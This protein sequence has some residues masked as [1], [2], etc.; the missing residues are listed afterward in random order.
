MTFVER[1][2]S[3]S[4]TVPELHMHPCCSI[5]ESGSSFCWKQVMEGGEPAPV[6]EGPG[7][8]I[9]VGAAFVNFG[10]STLEVIVPGAAVFV[11]GGMS[12]SIGGRVR[13]TSTTDA[14][15]GMKEPVSAS[16][17]ATN[18]RHWA[19]QIQRQQLQQR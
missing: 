7:V 8:M 12:K 14:E 3:V 5:P 2:G 17:D 1:I 9:P 11:A 16:A 10:E 18:Q 4:V 19:Q 13:E 15:V 6:L